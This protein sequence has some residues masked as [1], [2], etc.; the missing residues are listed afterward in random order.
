MKEKKQRKE[1][2]K[3]RNR[4]LIEAKEQAMKKDGA[5]PLPESDDDGEGDDND[6]SSLIDESSVF[7][8]D[9]TVSMF[10]SAVS[11][12]VSD[13]IGEENDLLGGGEED[14]DEDEDGDADSDAEGGG[15]SV[16]SRI[17]AVS[18]AS[19]ALQRKKEA[20]KKKQISNFERAMK[21]AKQ[22]MGTKKSKKKDLS[23]ATYQRKKLNKKVESR[24]LL[25]K[26]L[27]T[28]GMQV[29][30]RKEKR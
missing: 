27:G 11:V 8:D 23:K 2:V 12:V 16:S 6:N 25:T 1:A 15:G 26:A 24:Q 4:I 7:A 19:I 21:K 18:A 14:S 22:E 3:S 29:R 5:I 17:S 9:A 28:K 30:K 10:G 13:Q 20:N